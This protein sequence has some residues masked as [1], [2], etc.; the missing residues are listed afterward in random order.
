MS[1]G[2]APRRWQHVLGEEHTVAQPKQRGMVNL[3]MSYTPCM[4]DPLLSLMSV[5]LVDCS[6][7]CMTKGAEN[8]TTYV[9]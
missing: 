8:M 3:A 7:A 5:M 1:T 9:A 2:Q 4:Q 6:P